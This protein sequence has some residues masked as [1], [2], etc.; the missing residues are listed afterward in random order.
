M[1]D[2]RPRGTPCETKLEYAAGAEKMTD[3]RKFREAV[4]S[5]VYLST[6]TRPDISFVV[7]KLTQYFAEPT[8]E[9]WNQVKHVFRYLKCTTEQELS[10]KRNE[11]Q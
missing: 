8:R 9:H 7:C 4:G 3:P 11:T 5:L 2:C 1:Q 6:C 10:F